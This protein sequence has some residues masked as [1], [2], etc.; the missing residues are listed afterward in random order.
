MLF[1]PFFIRHTKTYYVC[2]ALHCIWAHKQP[3]GSW[4]VWFFMHN[5][6][7]SKS[8]I[9]IKFKWISRKCLLF[10][11]F[12]IDRFIAVAAEF[13]G[14][15]QSKH[16]TSTFIP[17]HNCSTYFHIEFNECES[18]SQPTNQSIHSEWFSLSFF[19]SFTG[20]YL[21]RFFR[22]CFCIIDDYA[23]QYWHLWHYQPHRHS[24]VLLC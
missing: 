5:D 16:M 15:A 24:A 2:I 18:T 20:V 9:Y 10:L 14:S 1:V 19:H 21:P 6:T 8:P 13:V 12:I 7:Q 17:C 23:K 22:C 4:S 3:C 11:L